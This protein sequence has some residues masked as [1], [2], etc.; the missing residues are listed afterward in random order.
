MKNVKRYKW[1][2]VILA[3]LS[4]LTCLFL[5]AT[6]FKGNVEG[7]SFNSDITL[8]GVLI[9]P[10]GPGPHPAIVL[11][12]GA[13]SRHQAYDKQYFKFH[14][15]AFLKKGFAVLVYTKRGSGK[16]GF[17][18]KYFTYEKL[19]KDAMAA[20]D[21]LKKRDDINHESIGV[22][23]VSESGWFTPEL[24]YRD[25]TIKFII[26]RVSSPFNFI[27]TNSHEVVTDAL[28]QGFTKQEIDTEILPVTKQIWQF[29]IAVYKDSTVANG[30]Q[31]MAINDELERL[32]KHERF[33]KWFTYSELEAYDARS[34]E[35]SAKR[36]LY[37]PM[38]YFKE[39]TIPM[40][41][42]MAGNDKNI[43]TKKVVAFLNGI[44]SKENKDIKIKV[45]PEASHYLYKY[46]LEDGPF[47]GWLYYDDYLESMAHW[48]RN[49]VH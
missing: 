33:G 19:L 36:F 9:T 16:T 3:G 28:A 13:G 5:Y 38:P 32:N 11:L 15:N 22:M 37:D 2:L 44:K 34:Y 48:A 26:N 35:A 8:E 25:T 30:P 1:I 18:Y 14:A 27:H 21:F 49:Q 45:Y 46:G 10:D 17:D 29:Y 23:G 42:I 47:D 20:V 39:L 6:R 12:H 41:Y 24:A 7:I 4:L 40:F 43:P 31:R